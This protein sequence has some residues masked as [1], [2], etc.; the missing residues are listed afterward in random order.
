MQ[1]PVSATSQQREKILGRI[2]ENAARPGKLGWWRSHPKRSASVANIHCVAESQADRL[3]KGDDEGLEEMYL[4]L[5]D[6]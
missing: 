3:V 5:D 2:S 6:L 4:S 1:A